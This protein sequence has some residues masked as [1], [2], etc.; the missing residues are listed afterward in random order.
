ME[1]FRCR[2]QLLMGPGA[3]QELRTLK[4]ERLFLVT[5]PY[6]V[7][8]GMAQQVLR[9]SGAGKWEIFD[10]VVPDPTVE[11]AA[12]GTA[13]YQ[14]FAP[15]LLVAL[16]GG[17]SL[18]C[19][20]AISYF[21]DGKAVFCAIPTTSG[22]GSEVTDFAILTHDGV[23]HPL[24]DPRLQPDYAIL[25]SDLLQSLPR[26]LIA[27]A[28]FD[29][30]SHALEAVAAKNAGRMSSLLAM[31]SFSLA[32]AH[33]LRSY[34]GDQTARLPVHQA[35]A[36]AGLAFNHA[37]LGLCH[38][39][40]HCLGARFHVPHGRLNAILLPAVLSC[41][42]EAAAHAYGELARFAGLGGSVDAVA[43]RNL[44]N[45]LK[46]LRDQ[47]HLPS[48]LQQAG[49]DPKAVYGQLSEI[50]EDVLQDPCCATN[51]RPVTEELVKSLLLQVTEHG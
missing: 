20:K 16:G 5:D 3:L 38:G 45:G 30:L 4:A 23:K 29:V 31:D 27:D 14:K 15:D 12:E 9:M 28:G 8:S 33:L 48:T 49:V 21:A 43:F 40:S 18:D 26:S 13:A 41:N 44:Q 11:L 42:R 47:L 46:K 34:E 24:V 32:Y 50:A 25:D 37:G 36:M 35:A 1:K 6:F 17:S 2:T 10:K 39:I 22:S 19:A 7:K 51:P